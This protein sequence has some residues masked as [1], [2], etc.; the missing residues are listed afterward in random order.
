MDRIIAIKVSGSHVAK[1]SNFAGVQ[2]EANARVMRIE[3]DDGWDGYAK[4]VTF[5]NALGKNPVKRTLTADLLENVLENTRVY[6]CPI[7]KEAMTEAGNMQFVVDGY[8]DG[9]HQRSVSDKL[10]VDPA[11]YAE[12]AGYPSDPTPSQ[13]EQLQVQ[14]DTILQNISTETARAVSGAAQ[15]ANSESVATASASSA[16]LSAG[17]AAVSAQVAS[18]ARAAAEKAALMA[19]TVVGG[20]YAGIEYVDSAI[21][22][23]VASIPSPDVSGQIDTHNASTAAHSDIRSLA[24]AAQNT[25][26]GKVSKSG[27]TM[28]GSLQ[29]DISGQRNI[30]SVNQDRKS[31]RLNSSH[32]DSSR[33][34]SSA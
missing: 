25:A 8:A 34:P 33:M 4:T 16:A 22:A 14:I 10:R 18:E 30:V 7:P 12:D 13:A 31:T 6:L 26:S 28:T 17:N 9:K 32:T 27:D 24:T 29:I 11:P 1:E 19:Q 5:W 21:A 23:A 2:H 15:A 20:N 3:F